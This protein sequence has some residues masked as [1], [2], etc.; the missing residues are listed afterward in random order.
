MISFRR[1]KLKQRFLVSLI[2]VITLLF[3]GF[4][5]TVY[6]NRAQ[7]TTETIDTVML[8]NLLD[9]R[10]IVDVIHEK[11]MQQQ[12]EQQERMREIRSQISWVDPDFPVYD[13]REARYE[14]LTH[15]FSASDLTYLREKLPLKEYYNTGFPFIVNYDGALLVHPERNMEN[16]ADEPFFSQMRKGAFDKIT[17]DD[18][19]TGQTLWLYY[20]DVPEQELFI[21]GLIKEHDVFTAPILRV[22]ALAGISFVFAYI[23]FI[24]L[25]NALANSVTRPVKRISRVLESIARGELNQEVKMKNKDEIGQMGLSVNG[26]IKALQ[27]TSQFAQEIGK[28]NYQHEFTPLSEKDEL[29]KALLEMRQSLI[30]ARETELVRK[31]DDDKRNWATEGLAKFGDILR[32]ENDEMDKLTYNIIS[33]LVEYLD[34]NQG[35]IFL[36]NDE[37]EK[38]VFL[39]LVACYAYER[40]K[41]L[42]KRFDPEEGLV[43][44]CFQEKATMLL[45]DFP[46][47]YINITSGL[48]GAVP[49]SLVLI[50]LKVNEECFG[51][52]E[53]ATLEKF[54]KHHVDFLERIAES[55]AATIGAV[56]TNIRTSRLLKQ[57]QLQQEEM[58]AH[59]EEMRQNMEELNATQ[60]EMGRKSLEMEG[61]MNAL[62][63]SNYIIIYD[64]DGNILSINDAYLKLLGLSEK[65]VV[66][67]HHSENID[68]NGTKGEEYEKFWD[69][70]RQGIIRIKESK[71]NINNNTYWMKETYGPILDSDGHPVKIFKVAHDISNF[72]KLEEELRDKEE[73]IRYNLE[74]IEESRTRV[75]RQGAEMEGYLEAINNALPC[76][77]YNLDGKIIRINDAYM[78]YALQFG[79]IT[80]NDILGRYHTDF[81]IPPEYAYSERYK[82]FWADLLAGNTR[83]MES[84]KNIN[85]RQVFTREIYTPVKDERGRV[86]KIIRF[87]FDITEEKKAARELEQLRAERKNK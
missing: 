11:N 72:K 82:E 73:K 14:E 66:G 52:L 80:K 20:M 42:E 67:K 36:L 43:G 55:I 84:E 13:L 46:D 32:Q 53:I 71:V 70:L 19:S 44:A 28:G 10:T 75:V 6:I 21:A 63:I 64:L 18:P 17:Y 30:T 78:E 62:N 1:L 48:G 7:T 60:E 41:F 22:M 27:K 38:D 83:R 2:F 16:V 24:L 39:E 54:E 45:V 5:S 85:S 69:D 81:V 4:G 74:E 12:A 3:A 25:V 61:I 87:N 58:R 59:E 40:K 76:I 51:V 15:G 34:A 65:D 57:S 9:L 47:D 50:P 37:N 86:F 33:K 26:I 23:I 29:G 77:E 56:K 35:G 68:M 31:A 49:R 8:G 79:E